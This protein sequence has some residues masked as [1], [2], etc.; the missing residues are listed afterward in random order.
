MAEK[1]EVV[2]SYEDVEFLGGN[3]TREVIVTGIRTKPSGIYV[4]VRVPKDTF[5]KIGA[6]A[7]SDAANSWSTLFETLVRNSG[8]VGVQWG[9]ETHNGQLQDVAVVTAESDSG[10]T[11]ASLT[12]PIARL[13]PNLVIPG[14]EKLRKQLSEL[15]G[16]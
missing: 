1:Y 4:E 6:H 9:Q 7:I 15:E 3:R 11:Q 12:V 16:L 2:S 5:R 10:A 14:L 13:G 8:V